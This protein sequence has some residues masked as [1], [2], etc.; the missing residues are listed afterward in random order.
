MLVQWKPKD[1]DKARL[2]LENIKDL[3][4]DWRL[5]PRKQVSM[6]VVES[7][8]RALLAGANFP[9]IKVGIL[10]GQKIIVDGVHRVRSRE[11]LN[12]STI[13]A[14][15]LEFDSEAELFAEAVRFNSAHGKG[16]T[17][18]E[19]WANVDRLKKYEFDIN[20][21]VA[22]CHIPASE[23]INETKRP[24]LSITSPSGKKI[25]CTKVKP[26]E[27]GI[28]GLLCLKNALLIVCNW[29]EQNKIP[30]EPVIKELVIRARDALAKVKFNN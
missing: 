18:E 13:E 19:V 10:N 16:Y 27:H 21:I 20:D 4:L 26:G 28:R 11:Q 7:Y 24:I 17:E 22:I 9:P 1:W 5:Y 2:S 3:K 6:D 8:A 25:P 29:A 30:N 23:I 15:I 14:L 12:I